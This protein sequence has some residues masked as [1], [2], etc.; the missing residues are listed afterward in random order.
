MQAADWERR[1]PFRWVKRSFLASLPLFLYVPAYHRQSIAISG[2]DIWVKG[3]QRKSIVFDV[4]DV[5]RVLIVP[6]ARKRYLDAWGWSDTWSLRFEVRG[7][8]LGDVVGDRTAL[9]WE[10]INELGGDVAEILGVPFEPHRYSF[11]KP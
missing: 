9:V 4:A 8:I 5:R 11:P 1:I 10:E 7:V 3:W 2:D 6:N